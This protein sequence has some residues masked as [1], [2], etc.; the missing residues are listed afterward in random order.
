MD[1]LKIGDAV[2]RSKNIDGEEYVCLNDFEQVV[3]DARIDRWLSNLSTVEVLTAWEEVYNTDFKYHQLMVFKNSFKRVARF[4]LSAGK[5]MEFGGRAVISSR[6][7][8]GG[9][10]A[11]IDIALHYA[12]WLDAKFNVLLNRAFRLL[13]K[14]KFNWNKSELVWTIQKALNNSQENTVVLRSLQKILQLPKDWNPDD[15]K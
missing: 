11:H 12:S 3:P 14:E 10:W 7:R 1:K 13:I 9:T 8:G 5:W 15:Y 2:I 6:G 4:S